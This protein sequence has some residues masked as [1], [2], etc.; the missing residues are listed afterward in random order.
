MSARVSTGPTGWCGLALTASVTGYS[1]AVAATS[2]LSAVIKRRF[3]PLA[4]LYAGAIAFTRSPTF[5][6]RVRN[7]PDSIETTAVLT[8]D[9]HDKP[10][11]TKIHLISKAKV[12]N[13]DKAKF[14]ELAHNAEIGCPIS[15]LLG[16]AATITLDA[17]LL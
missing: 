9:M 17:T 15:R 14:D 11:V 12:P 1:C 2:E 5:R 7:G 10:T 8:L 3:G 6:V 13:I 16:A 4:Y